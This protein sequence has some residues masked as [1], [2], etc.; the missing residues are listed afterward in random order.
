MYKINT[1]NKFEKDFVRCAKRKYNLD[2]LGK[3]IEILEGSGELPS[4]YK[5]HILSGNYNGYMECHIKPDW[6]LIWRQ[7]NK[8][9][10]IE[11]GVNTL[12]IIE[13]MFNDYEQ[14]GR[15]S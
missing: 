1:T 9:K 13:D 11:D 15:L 4:K 10:T 3:L 12:D 6:L 2:E 7:N 5:P 8:T 14:N